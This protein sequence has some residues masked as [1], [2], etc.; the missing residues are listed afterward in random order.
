MPSSITSS[1]RLSRH[2]EVAGDSFFFPLSLCV[3]LCHTQ[4]RAPSSTAKIEILQLQKEPVK[5]GDIRDDREQGPFCRAE[6][7]PPRRKNDR[8][9]RHLDR[10]LLPSRRAS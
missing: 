2:S 5:S 10:V 7:N 6:R 3:C 8:R 1:I 4:A 9:R